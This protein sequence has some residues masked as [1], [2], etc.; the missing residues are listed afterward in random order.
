MLALFRVK[1]TTKVFHQ[2]PKST[3]RFHHK[4]VRLSA[5][6]KLPAKSAENK[7]REKEESINLTQVHEVNASNGSFKPPTSTSR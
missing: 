1:T 2:L 4:L 6:A 7:F 3:F 5:Q